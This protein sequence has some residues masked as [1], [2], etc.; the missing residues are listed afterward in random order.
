MMLRTQMVLLLLLLLSKMMMVMGSSEKS[1]SYYPDHLEKV[2]L[3]LENNPNLTCEAGRRGS[4]QCQEG[5]RLHQ[6]AEGGACLWLSQETAAWQEVLDICLRKGGSVAAI[7]NR[8]REQVINDLMT[9]AGVSAIWTVRTRYNAQDR[10]LWLL[11]GRC[12]VHGD[13]AKQYPM[14]QLN[15]RSDRYLLPF[16]CQKTPEC[17]SGWTGTGCCLRKEPA[18]VAYNCVKTQSQRLLV[19]RVDPKSTRYEALQPVDAVGRVQA[20]CHSIE[21]TRYLD[22]F[23][24]VI[25]VPV[26]DWHPRPC[27]REKTGA[28]TYTWRLSLQEKAGLQLPYDR[29]FLASCEF[30]N[31]ETWSRDVEYSVKLNQ[32]ESLTP[33]RENVVLEVVDPV[34][35]DVIQEA[36]LGRFVKLRMRLNV[37]EDSLGA[38]GVSPYS[39]VATSTDGEY[40][41]PLTDQNGCPEDSSLMSSFQGSNGTATA[42]IFQLFTVPGQSNVTLACKIQFCLTDSMQPICDDR[43]STTKNG[44]RRR[45]MA[46]DN[47]ET[48]STQVLVLPA[49][50]SRPSRSVPVFDGGHLHAHMTTPVTWFF[51]VILLAMSG[52]LVYMLYFCPNTRAS[53]RVGKLRMWQAYDRL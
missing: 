24:Y 40:Q 14:H 37:S 5:W 26:Q 19:L 10:N 35:D 51:V 15:C 30:D 31:A 38:V 46:N 42:S 18:D 39:C 27:G 2:P 12:R 45:R 17:Q 36:E 43:C 22:T 3:A 29:N 25:Q 50:G 32:T 6:D 34:T 9:E 48:V 21:V 23:Q 20:W 11:Q 28:N 8:A 1:M 53:S 16:I 41:R 47:G 4:F 7:E 52:G 49:T 33:T 44:R 13:S